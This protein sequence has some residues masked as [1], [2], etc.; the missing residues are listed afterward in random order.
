MGGTKE[1]ELVGG[2]T[3]TEELDAQYTGCHAH[4]TETYAHCT[5]GTRCSR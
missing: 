2:P 1:Y 4:G 3:K 5:M